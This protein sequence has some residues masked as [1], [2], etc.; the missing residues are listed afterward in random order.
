MHADLPKVSP[1]GLE[2]LTRADWFPGREA[3]VERV[4]RAVEAQGFETFPAWDDV[5]KSLDG[6]VVH[7]VVSGDTARF[8][9]SIDFSAERAIEWDV[10]RFALD[11]W[12]DRIGA[13][14]VTGFP[15][16]PWRRRAARVM[17]Q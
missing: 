2:A 15:R 3:D 5:I 6:I 12:S 7:R 13:V 11:R 16:S 10:V 8:E 4:R 17:K 1:A 9:Q 14:V